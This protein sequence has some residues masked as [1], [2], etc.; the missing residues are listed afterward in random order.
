MKSFPK[1]LWVFVMMSVLLT[2]CNL[3]SSKKTATPDSASVALTSAAGTVGAIITEQ[4]RLTAGINTPIPPTAAA[5]QGVPTAAPSQTTQPQA[6]LTPLPPSPTAKP[7]L[8]NHAEFVTDVTIP[9][10]TQLNPGQAFTKT[11]RLINK[12]TCTWTTG[13]KLVFDNG[14]AM[15]SPVTVAF[16]A[17]VKPEETVDLSVA[18]VAPQAAGNYEGNWKLQDAAGVKFGLGPGGTGFL[19]VKIGVGSASGPFA[20]THIGMTASPSSYSGTCPATVTFTGTMDVTAPGTVT[21]FWEFSDG[22]QGTLQSL[23]FT[24]AGT[25]TVSTS[26]AV[27]SPGQSLNGYARLYVDKPN[28]QYFSNAIFS[29]TCNP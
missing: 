4:A 29:L 2:A 26:W 28:H 13:Y 22:T 18:L 24:A 1:I 25:K 8:C 9:D 27:G 17:S 20:V 23:E 16:P 6:S 12:G 10:Q 19:W 15:Q 3:P 14:N 5:T 21:Y 7:A 11:W